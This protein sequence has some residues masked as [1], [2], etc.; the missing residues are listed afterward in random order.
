MI[1]TGNAI[2]RNVKLG[3]DR[4]VFLT[5]W[6]ELQLTES[7]YQ[8]FGGWNLG[9]R[10]RTLRG[11]PDYT[12]N[13]IIRCLEIGDVEQW[14]DLRGKPI[15]YRKEDGGS[16]IAIGHIIKDDWF[17]PKV[18]FDLIKAASGMS[19]LGALHD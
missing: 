7:G 8:S 3:L 15:R 19:T 5:P 18:D 4:D 11:G 10:G 12:A 13:F 16:I 2:I 1:E 9:T 17:D 6:L 14:V